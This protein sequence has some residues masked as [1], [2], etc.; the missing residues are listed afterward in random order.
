MDHA[1]PVA[2]PFGL[3]TPLLLAITVIAGCAGQTTAPP[4]ILRCPDTIQKK[5]SSTIPAVTVSYREPSVT[6]T[7]TLLNDLAKTTIYYDLGKGRR[8]AKE[9]PAS[10]P[11]GGGKV[12]ETIAIP[13]EKKGEQTVRICV[14][15]TDRQGNESRATR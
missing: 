7:G 3:T 11:I 8:P 15:A 12:S 2:V 4:T 1:L 5:V 6:S 14:T 10:Q 13:F 9:V